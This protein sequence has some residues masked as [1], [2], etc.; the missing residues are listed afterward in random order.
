MNSRYSPFVTSGWRAHAARGTLDV[1]GVSLSKAEAGAGV[2]DLDDAV[3]HRDEL[4]LARAS[5][6]RARRRAQRGEERIAAEQVLDVGE[7]QLLVLLLVIEAERDQECELGIVG[8]SL[9]QLAHVCVD[10]LAIGEYFGER[11]GLPP[12]VKT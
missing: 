6:R 11:D 7:H 3:R 5:G 4:E 9:E 1:R 2:A 8:A 12:R 10:V